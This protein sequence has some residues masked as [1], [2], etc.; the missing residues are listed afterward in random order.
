MG[1]GQHLLELLLPLL[2]GDLLQLRAEAQILRHRHIRIQGRQL[3]QISDVLPGGL[4]LLQDV[5]A[6]HQDLALRG[7]QIPGHHIHG[8]GFPGAVGPQEAKD[9][10]VLHREAQVVHRV[11]V[12]VS[13]H[14]VLD[15]DH[16]NN[17]LCA[18]ADGACPRS[19][20]SVYKRNLKST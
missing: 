7:G 1:Q 5:V 17:L 13:L 10:A 4:R 3:R 20:A 11:V 8:G 9:L 15:L 12:P 18:G 16:T 6:L 19:A 2:L 14:Q